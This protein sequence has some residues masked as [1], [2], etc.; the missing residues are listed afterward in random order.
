LGAGDSE[1]QVIDL[2]LTIPSSAQTISE[3]ASSGSVAD[4][5]L[6]AGQNS[7]PI[8]A[9]TFG[10]LTGWTHWIHWPVGRPNGRMRALVVALA[11]WAIAE[12][13]VIAILLQRRWA[14]AAPAGIAEVNIETQDPG[15]SV[16]VDGRPVGVTPFQLKIGAETRSISVGPPSRQA[17]G[18]T[19]L[20]NLPPDRGRDLPAEAAGRTGGAQTAA[21]RA[22]QRSGGIRFVSPI[23]LEV[24]EGDRRLGSSATG[25]VSARA[26][27]HD[28]ELV[29][30]VLGFR[31]R[32]S[33]EVRGGQV[34]SVT[35][36]PPNGRVNINAAPWAE[37][38]VDGRPMGE[39]PIGNLSLPLGEHEVVF[40]HPQFGE[41]RK[42]VVVRLDGVTRVSASF[43]R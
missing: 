18:S 7:A 29:N 25:I 19:G 30:S 34:V 35:V 1:V 33:V 23:E 4:G 32:Q 38:W 2:P 11:L 9:L 21:A 13:F 36:S 12:G 27:R 42:T 26:G 22:P 6:S 3:T 14:A 15:A 28:L 17:V 24:F 16:L 40:R 43:P 41:Q 37:V 39:T 20:Q 5:T 8:S 10:G 31:S